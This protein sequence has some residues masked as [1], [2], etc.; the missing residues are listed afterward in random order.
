MQ[1]SSLERSSLHPASLQLSPY[2]QYYIRKLLR[3]YVGHVHPPLLEAS[4]QS[5]FHTDLAQLLKQLYPQGFEYSL[6]IQELQMLVQ[7][8]QA[9]DPNKISPYEN[10]AEIE[11]K[12]FWILNLRVLA[13]IQARSL[14]IVPESTTALFHFVLDQQ[15]HQGIR[16]A[17]ELYG[18][19]LEFSLE[20]DQQA[21]YLLLEL[22][23]QRTP[24]IMTQSELSY[25]IWVGLRS[26][27]YNSFSN[28]QA[29]LEKVA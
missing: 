24:F 7:L 20:Q 16:H 21:Y 13:L 17:D 1:R 28:R 22:I 9:S 26:D 14:T 5:Y 2:T 23:E 8:H 18:K 6:K 3:Q 27:A 19:V 15:V 12:I 29:Q 11:R 25:G 4:I 10:L